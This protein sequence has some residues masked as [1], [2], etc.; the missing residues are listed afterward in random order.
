MSSVFVSGRSM[1]CT[2]ANWQWSWFCTL[3]YW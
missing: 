1:Y 2:P 3:F